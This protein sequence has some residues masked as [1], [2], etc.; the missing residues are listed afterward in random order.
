[1][2]KILIV[3]LL[4]LT[5]CSTVVPVA[6]KFPKLAVNPKDAFIAFSS[7]NLSIQ[8]ALV[9]VLLLGANKTSVAPLLLKFVKCKL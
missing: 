1:M 8:N 5:G 9:T 2:N 4:T 7:F 6:V 3:L